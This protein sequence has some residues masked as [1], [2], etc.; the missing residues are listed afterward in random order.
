VPS[1][2][3]DTRVPTIGASKPNGTDVKFVSEFHG[4]AIL[5][6]KD[7]SIQLY[8][9]AKAKTLQITPANFRHD[10]QAILFLK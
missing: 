7:A 3:E 1:A 2:A 10:F 4:F 9:A 6:F 8:D 5:G